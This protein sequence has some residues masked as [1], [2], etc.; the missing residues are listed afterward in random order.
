M[1]LEAY[2]PQVFFLPVADREI[3]KSS[4]SASTGGFAECGIPV[5]AKERWET[6]LFCSANAA[7]RILEFRK[8]K[9]NIKI[10]IKYHRVR[11][12]DFQRHQPVAGLPA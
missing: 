2:M 6:E 4:S 8:S 1:D 5:L 7:G 9:C 11:W 10:I 3:L 12:D